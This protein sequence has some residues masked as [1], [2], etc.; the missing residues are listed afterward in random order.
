[1]IVPIKHNGYVVEF[2]VYME[3]SA[4]SRSGHPDTWYEGY[5]YF[6][7][8][9]VYVRGVDNN[10]VDLNEVDD[11]NIVTWPGNEFRITNQMLEDEANEVAW[12]DAQMAMEP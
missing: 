3:G 9:D 12:N 5:Y 2:D 8:N 4:G 10:A 7:V 6:E 1:M 11:V